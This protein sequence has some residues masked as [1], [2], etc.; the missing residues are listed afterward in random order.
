MVINLNLRVIIIHIDINIINNYKKYIPKWIVQVGQ[1]Q[2]QWMLNKAEET[3]SQKKNGSSFQPL[4]NKG[5]VKNTTR[6]SYKTY[7]T[8]T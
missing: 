3:N 7:L 5:W 1:I 8:A 6:K 2:K 4:P